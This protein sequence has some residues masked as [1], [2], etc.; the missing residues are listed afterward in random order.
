MVRSTNKGPFVAHS[1][2]KKIIALKKK[3]EKKIVN[4]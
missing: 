1:I 2:L 4:T 3:G